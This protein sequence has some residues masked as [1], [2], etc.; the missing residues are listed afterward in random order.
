MRITELHAWDVSPREAATLQARMAASV[1]RDGEVAAAGV[2]RIAGADVAFDRANR[3]GA[4]AVVV[5]DYPSLEI[6]DR[7]T[8]EA[9]VLFP[10]VP[11]LLSFR[12]TPVLLRA[13]EQLAEAPDLLMV[14]GHGYAHPRRFGFACHLGL[15]LDVPTIGVAKSRLIGEAHGPAVT[16]GARADLVDAGETVGGVLRTREGVRP[17]YVSVGHRIGLPAAERWVLACAGRYRVPA[18]TRLADAAAGEARRSMLAGTIE[19]VVEQRAGEHGRWEWDAD[20][21]EVLFRHELD[22]MPLHYGCSTE[23]LNDADGELLDVLLVDVAERDRAERLNVR[24]LD[25]LERSDGDHK[26]LAVPADAPQPLEGA[27]ERAW[28]WFVAHEKPV[29]RW[30]GEAAAIALI[31]ACRD[32]RGG[33]HRNGR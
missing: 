26:L 7:V 10:Y 29:V 18:P 32:G 6:V 30:G 3:R 2:R 5:L 31:E 12:E 19:M 14:D 28:A 8:V 25:V 13:F 22:P 11:G 33:G 21:E 1:V 16:R 24:V 4:G 9:P 15:L 23:L 20:R 27:R 17:V